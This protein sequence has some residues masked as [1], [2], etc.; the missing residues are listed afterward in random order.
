[1][2]AILSLCKIDLCKYLGGPAFFCACNMNPRIAAE[3]ET[4]YAQ[5][6]SLSR[7]TGNVSHNDASTLRAHTDK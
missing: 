4:S 2:A 3:I 1:M 5:K 6:G 7:M